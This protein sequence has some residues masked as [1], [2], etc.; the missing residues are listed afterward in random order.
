MEAILE[1]CLYSYPYLKLAKCYVFLIIAYIFSSTKLEKGQN[2][3]CLEV[4]GV[5]EEGGCGRQGKRWPNV[6]T[7]E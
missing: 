4:K 7:Y 6:R 1:I 5:V 2:L 3:Y